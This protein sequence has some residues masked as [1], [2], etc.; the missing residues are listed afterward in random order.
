[1]TEI[2]PKLIPSNDINILELRAVN[3]GDLLTMKLPEREL[4][5][6][7]W[8]SSQGLAMIYAPRG[9]GK[10]HVSLGIACAVAAGTSFLNWD[11]PEPQGVLFIDGEMPANLL[12]ERL[13]GIMD[14]MEI[15]PNP[16][17]LKFITPDFQS[18]GIPDLATSAGQHAI[19]QFITKETKL[20]ILD[21]I[22]TLVRS[23]KENEAESWMPVQNWALQQRSQGRTVLFIHHS[24]KSGA[25]RGTSRREDVLDTVIAL[26]KPSDYSPDQGACFEVHFEKARAIYGDE[27]APFKAQLITEENRQHWKTELLE[28]SNY[29]KAV[30]MLKD[31]MSQREIANELCINKST[32]SRYAKKAKNE[33]RVQHE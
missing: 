8:L 13:T 25:Q 21:N 10:T 24:G 23:G 7:P 9:I 4:I 15:N 27:T 32:A 19:N 6:E 26:K 29:E 11:V 30:Q 22:S 18:M 3:I 33:G 20:I 28:E 14:N 12:Q 16:D 31:G 5:M 17:L 2:L 1:M